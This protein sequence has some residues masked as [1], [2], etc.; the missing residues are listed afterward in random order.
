M[1]GGAADLAQMP[2]RPILRFYAEHL[3]PATGRTGRRIR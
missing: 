1:E 3:A 2:H